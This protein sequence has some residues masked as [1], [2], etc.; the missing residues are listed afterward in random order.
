MAPTSID[1]VGCIHTCQGLELDYVGVIIGPDLLARSGK[2]VSAPENRS[3]TD[4]SIRGYRTLMR[5]DPVGAGALT[6]Q[7][8]R[9]TY[10]TLMTRGLKGCFIYCTDAETQAHF[11]G[12]IS[13]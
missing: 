1:E 8:I 7:I 11:Q 5:N 6:D 2:L 13:R 9:N 3:R 4:K 10:K 12:V